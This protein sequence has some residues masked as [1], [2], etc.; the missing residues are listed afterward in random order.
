MVAGHPQWSRW[1]RRATLCRELFSV[2]RSSVRT[3]T[4]EALLAGALEEAPPG[5]VSAYLFGSH[6]EGRAHRE[7]DVDVGV[8]LS[9]ER[10]AT[11]RERFEVRVRLSSSLAAALRTDAVDVVI[12][13]DAPPHLARRIV[14]Q[15]RRVIEALAEL[16]PV[17]RFLAIVA[18]LESAAKS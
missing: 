15:G 16:E 1:P 2:K 8:L 10:Y 4:A 7:S 5:I 14:T 6:A 11:Q 17:E 9:Y 18:R 12:L 3:K 13:N